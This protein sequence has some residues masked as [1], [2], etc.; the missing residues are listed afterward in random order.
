MTRNRDDFS[1]LQALRAGI[2]GVVAILAIMLALG[3][4]VQAS[5]EAAERRATGVAA[6]ALQ[7]APAVVDVA[8]APAASERG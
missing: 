6:A 8:A 5:K 3:S 7:F 1:A 4:A 2:L